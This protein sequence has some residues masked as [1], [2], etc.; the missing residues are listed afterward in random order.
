MSDQTYFTPEQ[1]R[2]IA[3]I[4][5]VNLSSPHAEHNMIQV[6]PF[7][8]VVTLLVSLVLFYLAAESHIGL[9]W[10]VLAWVG[11]LTL[12]GDTLA[13]FKK[14]RNARRIKADSSK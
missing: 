3:E 13:A 7:H 14:A 5:G 8:L 9:G 11:C 10:A 2:R 4:C 6:N 12:T 1:E